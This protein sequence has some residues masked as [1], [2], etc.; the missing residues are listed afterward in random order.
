VLT[1]G[2]DTSST[3]TIDVLLASLQRTSG[4][5]EEG[6]GSGTVPRVFT[7]GYGSGADPEVLKKIAE[8]GGGAY[9]SGDPKNIRSV[10]AELATFF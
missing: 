9:F 3:A 4:G 10:Y 1:D 8:A 2:K 6:T 7:I 5:G